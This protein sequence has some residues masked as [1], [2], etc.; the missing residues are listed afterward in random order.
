MSRFSKE[1]ASPAVWRILMAIEWAVIVNELAVKV[2]VADLKEF[3]AEA[4]IK[5]EVDLELDDLRGEVYTLEDQIADLREEYRELE[6][7]HEELLKTVERLR[8][9]SHDLSVTLGT[10]PRK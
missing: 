10:I 1:R 7:K 6:E 9:Y 5:D 8:G 4:E 3:I 2:D